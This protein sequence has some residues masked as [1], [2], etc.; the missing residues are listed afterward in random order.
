MIFFP[1]FKSI[2]SWSGPINLYGYLL[3]FSLS[4]SFLYTSLCQY[5]FL[6]NSSSKF[7]EFGV[8][9][10]T[11]YYNHQEERGRGRRK[12]R[13]IWTF[14]PEEAEKEKPVQ[15]E[16]K[17]TCIQGWSSPSKRSKLF[18][19]SQEMVILSTHITWK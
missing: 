4:P 11:S 6:C 2:Q 8:F 5:C 13:R 15:T 7:K 17:P 1:I 9:T 16:L 18:T 10:F 19:T 14:G 3:R 12:R